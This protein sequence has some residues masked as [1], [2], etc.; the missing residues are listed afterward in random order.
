MS[1]NIQFSTTV[2]FISNFK[3]SFP[4]G[5]ILE[6]LGYATV[7]DGG[8]AKW[9][10]TS[11]TGQTVSQSPAQLATAL[12]NDANGNQWALVVAG[13]LNSRKLGSTG[14]GSTDDAP[15]LQAALNSSKDVFIPQGTYYLGTGLTKTG[16]FWSIVGSGQQMTILKA[17]IGVVNLLTVDNGG[18]DINRG[19]IASLMMLPESPDQTEGTLILFLDRVL[20]T[21][22]DDVLFR[23]FYRAISTPAGAAKLF[24]DRVS[25]DMVGRTGGTAGQC[26]FYFADGHGSDIHMTRVNGS[27]GI[28]GSDRNGLLNHFIINSMDGLYINNSHFVYSEIAMQITPDATQTVASIKVAGDVYFDTARTRHISIEGIAGSL[29]KSF[30][31]MGTTFR[32]GGENC[33]F[34]GSAVTQLTFVGCNFRTFTASAIRDTETT[35][36]SALSITGCLFDG[37]NTSN[38]SGEGDIVTRCTGSVINS[39]TFRGGGAS[40]NCVK[41]LGTLGTDN[42]VTSNNMSASTCTTKIADTGSGN[43]TTGNLL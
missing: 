17:A 30:S 29:V 4:V 13:T 15:A 11:T 32:E 34:I 18:A 12:L 9:K 33:I 37:N 41:I 20:W 16:N 38:T 35:V 39:N 24:I 19:K 43:I 14:N 2:L 27:G 36:T 1:S 8:G 3:A 21:H 31:F 23:A 6:T 10:K 40:G 22:I 5:T 42:I 26:A 7:G 25:Y 28:T